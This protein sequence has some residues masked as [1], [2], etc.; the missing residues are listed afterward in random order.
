MLGPCTI[1]AVVLLIYADWKY[2]ISLHSP[3]PLD[4]YDEYIF[5]PLRG[6]REEFYDTL[7]LAAHDR[8]M[9]AAEGRLSGVSQALIP[10]GSYSCLFLSIWKIDTSS[11]LAVATIATLCGLFLLSRNRQ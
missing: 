1:L 11:F 9:P 8:S 7:I 10:G 6:Q 4:V 2:H 3:A 5:L